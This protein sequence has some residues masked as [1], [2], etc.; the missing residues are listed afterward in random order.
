MRGSSTLQGIFYCP[1]CGSQLAHSLRDEF[2]DVLKEEFGI[3]TNLEIL[4]DPSLPEE[5][6][7]DLWWKKRGL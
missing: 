5:F 7:S 4:K 6:K 1:W 3:E 2:F